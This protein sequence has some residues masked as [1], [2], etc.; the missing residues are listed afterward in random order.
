MNK[1]L[2]AWP[3][4]LCAS[5]GAADLPPV[6]KA[7]SDDTIIVTGQRVQQ[8]LS[9]VSGSITVI[10]QEELDRQVAS[11]LT[12][13]FR[14]IPGVSVT[15]SAGRPQNISVRGIGGNRILLIKDG[16]RVSDG[17]GADNI[18]DKVGRFN[19][20]LDDI[21]QIEVAKGAGSSLHGSDAI[22][23]TVVMNTKQPEDYLQQQDSY[24]AAKTLYGGD[25]NK[26]KLSMTAMLFT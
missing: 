1:L 24:L 16:V 15:G 3:A 21:K 5:A 23:G 12:H 22:G 6:E 7:R 13:V 26:K 9:D 8:K 17:F 4:L 2:Q 18:N 25:S 11:E 14:K 20:D 10:T 19:F